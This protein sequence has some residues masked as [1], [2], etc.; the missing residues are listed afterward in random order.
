REVDSVETRPL[1]RRTG[2][3]YV[4]LGRSRLAQHGDESALGVATHD[5]VVDDDESLAGDHRGERVQLEPDTELSD[6]LARL[7]ER[8]TDVG[9][10]HQTVPERDGAL[11]G[12]P[13]RRRRT[14]FR[15][16]DHQVGIDR[17]LMSEAASRLDPDVVQPL[18]GDT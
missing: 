1:D 11:L 2:D 8:T 6:R 5:R 16:G 7:D 17:H 15:Y 10:L 9:V 4:H 3:A 18:L 12:V 14:R 13:D